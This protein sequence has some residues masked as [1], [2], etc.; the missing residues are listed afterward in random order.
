MTLTCKTRRLDFAQQ[1]IN[2]KLTVARHAASRN[3]PLPSLPAGA[4]VTHRIVQDTRGPTLVPTQV[5]D[6]FSEAEP[7]TMPRCRFVEQE[8]ERLVRT[9]R[10]S[11]KHLC[12]RRLVRWTTLGPHAK[13]M[14]GHLPT[15][16]ESIQYALE[17]VIS[18]HTAR[19][20]SES[21]IALRVKF[22]E[23]LAPCPLVIRCARLVR[24]ASTQQ[25]Q[26]LHL[27]LN[28]VDTLLDANPRARAT[29]AVG[30]QHCWV[31][32][33]SEQR[34]VVFDSLPQC[35]CSPSPN[36]SLAS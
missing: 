33:T 5:H 30:L 17:R 12:D 34:L 21:L 14:I 18:P 15:E 13:V 6:Y 8:T 36:L 11:N 28:H 9:R 2:Q 25:L 22:P 1:I 23:G 3:T 24:Y 19:R 4:G 31:T 27:A 29:C 35:L 20:G 10:L 16:R 32:G 7:A 26:R